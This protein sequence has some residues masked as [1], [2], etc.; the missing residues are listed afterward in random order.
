[1]PKSALL[2]QIMAFSI[3]RDPLK[4]IDVIARSIRRMRRGNL[5]ISETLQFLR[6]TMTN[7]NN[8]K[9]GDCS[10]LSKIF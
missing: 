5:I 9:R 6:F 8:K 4:C 3:K 7:T 2:L 1:M 10:P